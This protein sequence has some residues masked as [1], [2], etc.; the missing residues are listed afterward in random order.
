MFLVGTIMMAVNF[1]QTIRGP[2]AKAVAATPV[3][4]D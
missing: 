3:A 2:E 4:A 1:W